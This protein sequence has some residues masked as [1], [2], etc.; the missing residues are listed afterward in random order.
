M[1]N[2]K[3]MIEAYRAE[4]GVKHAVAVRAVRARLAARLAKPLAPSTT[5]TPPPQ[6]VGFRARIVRLIE[7]AKAAAIE[8]GEDDSEAQGISAILGEFP[9]PPRG[10][11][12]QALVAEIESFDDADTRKLTSL[13]YAGRERV[14]LRTM[15]RQLRPDLPEHERSQVLTKASGALAIYLSRALF[16]AQGASIDLDAP[17]PD[18]ELLRE[19]AAAGISDESLDRWD[20]QYLGL[21]AIAHGVSADPEIGSRIARENALNGHFSLDLGHEAKAI[22]KA[23]GERLEKFLVATKIPFSRTS[24]TRVYSAKPRKPGRQSSVFAREDVRHC[25]AIAP[26]E[27]GWA[28]SK[29][30]R[31]EAQISYDHIDTRTAQGVHVVAP[32]FVELVGTR[33]QDR[34][35][36]QF[37]GRIDA[38]WGGPEPESFAELEQWLKK[39]LGADHV[40]VHSFAGNIA[41]IDA[42]WFVKDSGFDRS[43]AE[44]LLTD[45]GVL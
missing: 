23:A 19:L 21:H 13:M 29:S 45:M 37:S 38:L 17:L 20:P 42:I 31:E 34:P 2:L 24:L 41:Q 40:I 11:A 25:G 22:P 16:K 15:H 9:L 7:L 35:A 14:S 33:L 30:F 1:G 10:P 43:A 12:Y 4:H 18:S 6:P 5:A 8:G 27:P 36:W 28:V 44:K 26:D 32:K 3:K 39:D